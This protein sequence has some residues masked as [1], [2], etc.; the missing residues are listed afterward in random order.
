MAVR[1]HA[2]CGHHT[3]LLVSGTVI[4]GIN[5]N[6]FPLSWQVLNHFIATYIEIFTGKQTWNYSQQWKHHSSH[7]PRLRQKVGAAASF[8][9][10]N[11]RWSLHSAGATEP[12]KTVSHTHQQ[13]TLEKLPSF[14]LQILIFP[15]NQSKEEEADAWREKE[16][17]NFLSSPYVS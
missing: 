16:P 3:Q 13:L 9:K 14:F 12:R 2:L 1:E 10:K 11:Q 7:K 15:K 17:I 8:K 4:L 5:T 6:S